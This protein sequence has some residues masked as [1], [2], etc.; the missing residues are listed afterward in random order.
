MLM[1]DPD[2]AI[3]V[4][5][6]LYPLVEDG[7][8]IV[9]RSESAQKRLGMRRL[10][11]I[12]SICE[13][14]HFGARVLLDAEFPHII[15]ICGKR[16]SGKS[17]TLGVIA[18]EL[19]EKRV[20]AGIV[21]VDPIG[22]FWSIRYPNRSKAEVKMLSRF[23]L[24]PKGLDN[25]RVLAPVG[26]YESLKETVDSPFSIKVADMTAEDWCA[27]FDVN[28]FKVQGLLI[29][30]AIQKV[31][32]GYRSLSG[33][34]SRLVEGKQEYSID[35]I[36][37]CI[38]SDS[39]INSKARGYAR[40]TRRSVIARFEAAREWGLF[41]LEGT[42]IE[43]ISI[44]DTITVVDV[45]HPKLGENAR[46]LIVGILARKILEARMA[47]TRSEDTHVVGRGYAPSKSIPVTWLII[48]E[49][50][51]LLPHRGETPASAALVEYAKL[52]RKPGCALVLAT[53]RPAATNDDV[54][55]QVDV[56]IGHNLALEDDIVA[57]RR[58]VPARLPDS[59]SESDFI[60]SLPVG[61]AILA[62]QQTQNRSFIFQVRPRMSHHAGRQATPMISS[63]E[64]SEDQKEVG[65]RRSRREHKPS[66]DHCHASVSAT[67]SLSMSPSDA[68]FSVPA[69]AVSIGPQEAREIAAKRAKYHMTAEY[70]E[71]VE[72]LGLPL[73]KVTFRYVAK[74][75]LGRKVE[76]AMV[77]W[78][79]VTG[80]MVISFR[81]GIKRTEG[82][83]MLFNLS[84]LDVQ[85]FMTLTSPK[86][87]A[88][89]AD[90]MGRQISAVRNSLNALL[91]RGLV[92]QDDEGNFR[93]AVNM[94]IKMPRH[95]LPPVAEAEALDEVFEP[96][97]SE[98]E[99][100][101]MVSLIFRG[102]VMRCERLYYPYYRITYTSE[103]GS[104]Y[105]YIDAL[106]G[107]FDRDLE[108]MLK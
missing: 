6:P 9:G 54:L 52:G 49:A 83:P 30:S 2:C 42:P 69:F 82:V 4:D 85:V 32:E 35:D 64:R 98:K 51:L 41:S 101:R 29:G 58:R 18:E 12:G 79:A 31:R 16:G 23:G 91:Q 78:D 44:P 67:E 39:E 66:E 96:M 74:R 80:E 77:I 50:H 55:S 21:V 47:A 81:R 7:M 40:T 33:R 72:L 22:V 86:S 59:M 17:Y 3:H 13:S 26:Y 48:D 107:T 27:V 99:V 76:T 34:R 70:V 89:V 108:K 60:R 43:E 75:L 100:L 19:A 94:K 11:Y 15:F 24:V 84:D 56:M 37:A 63:V 97:L 87:A 88:D 1:A 57:L 95:T 8:V 10:L 28:R 14:N 92:V 71:D 102:E 106:S 104:K 93:S 38:E 36:V 46:A 90:E 61:V 65:S 25:V 5:V 53:Q 45:S 105:A 20:G 73:I 103:G 62:D 68:K